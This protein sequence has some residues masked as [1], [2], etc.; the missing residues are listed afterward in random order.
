MT[1][2]AYGLLSRNMGVSFNPQCSRRVSIGV[3]IWL[4]L[5]ET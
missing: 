5:S 1:M 4:S 2:I 3:Q